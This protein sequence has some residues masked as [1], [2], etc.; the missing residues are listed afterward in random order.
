MEI[1]AP[2]R[3]IKG[4]PSRWRPAGLEITA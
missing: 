1:V 2:H 4:D 3:G